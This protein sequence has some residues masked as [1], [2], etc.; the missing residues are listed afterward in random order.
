MFRIMSLM[1]VAFAAAPSIAS[2]QADTSRRSDSARTAQPPDTGRRIRAEAAGDVDT[3]VGRGFNLDLPN[4]GLTS[5]QAIELQQALARV[6]C[7]VGRPDGVVGG[8]TLRGLP[9]YRAQQPPT[10]AQVEPTMRA[11]NVRRATTP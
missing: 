8:R 10:V 4:F 3:R 11:L 2:A 6:G 1:L 9:C 5:A 7:D